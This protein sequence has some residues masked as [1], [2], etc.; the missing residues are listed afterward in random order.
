MMRFVEGFQWQHKFVKKFSSRNKE[1]DI[2]DNIFFGFR[3]TSVNVGRIFLMNGIGKFEPVSC[4]KWVTVEK[5]VE[6]YCWGINSMVLNPLHIH[7][8]FW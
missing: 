5:H 1:T 4:P 8:I 3:E 2:V 6:I 7:S